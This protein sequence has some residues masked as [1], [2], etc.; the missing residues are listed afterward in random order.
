MLLFALRLV[1]A[2]T[3]FVVGTAASHAGSIVEGA[4][5]QLLPSQ[6]DDDIRFFSDALQTTAFF[7]G[8]KDGVCWWGAFDLKDLALKWQATMPDQCQ[9]IESLAALSENQIISSVRN[10]VGILSVVRVSSEK[11]ETL[12]KLD[13]N[14]DLFSVVRQDHESIIMPVINIYGTDLFAV[15]GNNKE[16]HVR[17]SNANLQDL[18][19]AADGSLIVLARE[20]QDPLN[21]SYS[22]AVLRLKDGNIVWRTEMQGFAAE[23]QECGD[24]YAVFSVPADSTVEKFPTVPGPGTVTLFAND[25]V[26]ATLSVETRSD[27]VIEA[28]AF[29]PDCA[30]VAVGDNIQSEFAGGGWAKVYTASGELVSETRYARGGLYSVEIADSGQALAGG[31]A[32]IDGGYAAILAQISLQ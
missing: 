26:K 27:D 5:V 10:S 16:K 14:D 6:G 8:T 11:V 28:L 12:F 13:K 32:V 18:I 2:T 3:L 29:T 17:L 19:V 30:W 1:F 4:P 9:M 20:Y 25:A 21:K 24:G 7:S 23:V 31:T 15:K 22:S